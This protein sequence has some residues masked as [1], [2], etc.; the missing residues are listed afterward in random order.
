[1]WR[2][3]AFSKP[4]RFKLLS[5]KERMVLRR[6]AIFVAYFTLDAAL[7]VATNETEDHASVLVAIDSLVAKSLVET[8]PVGAI[9]YYRLFDT[10][11]SYVVD[12]G[13]DDFEATDL[14]VRHAIYCR[15]WLER[16]V[17]D[18]RG[19]PADAERGPYFAGLNNARKALEWCFATADQIEL[20]IA[21]AAAA[22]PVFL[23]MS[24]FAECH[25]WAEQAILALNGASCGG[26]EEMLLQA[27]MSRALLYTRGPSEAAGVALHR[28]LAIAKARSD[29]RTEV[30]L[31]ALVHQYHIRAGDFE[32]SLRCARR[33]SEIAST[34]GDADATAL[35]RTL[36]GISLHLTGDPRAA[37][38]ELE[39]VVTLRR[40]SPTSRT[41][42]LGFDY[43]KSGDI[44][45]TTSLWLL[46]YPAQALARARQ[47][48]KDAER[49]Q[50]PAS[51]SM[52]VNA[53]MVL[54]WLGDLGSAEEHLDWF[55]SRAQSQRLN[56]YSDVGQGLKGEFAIRRGQII[57]GIDM[58]QDC[59]RRLHA[60]RYGRFTTQF[61]MMLGRGLA[62]DD[63]FDEGLTLLD[64]TARQIETR[65]DSSHLPEVIRLK[66]G[67][68]LAMGGKRFK[69]EAEACF[70][71]SLE[72]S[73]ARR[74]RTW[75]LRTATDLAKLWIDQGRSAEAR[76]VLLQVFEQFTEGFETADLKAAEYLLETLSYVPSPLPR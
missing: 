10:T 21:L 1:M 29:H 42:Y 28:S 49:M 32:V 30:R 57:A 45:L 20:G 48:I 61:S 22:T 51:L 64:E 66:G 27:C 4:P 31:L 41:N 25:R 5:T 7:A 76:A 24:L 11:R 46:G 70:M 39:A 74:L 35:A 34:L 26:P 53:I 37:R 12:N 63:R 59:L 65:G 47:A 33:G 38:L 54:L 62:A 40:D 72:L 55:I 19:P 8:R 2:A 60:A 67:V 36:L 73:R 13:I 58:L 14:A 68:L 43:C 16:T 9:M 3:T 23:S 75:E 52:A 17:A 18:W 71:R 44:A 56:P 6:L 15:E 50:H 69:E